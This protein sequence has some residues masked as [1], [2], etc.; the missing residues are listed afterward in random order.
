MTT[1]FL[2]ELREVSRGNPDKGELYEVIKNSTEKNDTILIAP[3]L[4][5]IFDFER[6]VSRPSL[7]TFKYIPTSNATLIEWYKRLKFKEAVFS[8][9]RYSG[10]DYNY[11]HLIS[12]NTRTD[13]MFHA[14]HKKWFE[15]DSYIL[16]GISS[17]SPP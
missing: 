14:G 2:Q 8:G 9:S 17:S 15:N 16:W 12:S 10:S 5:K 1:N 4:E 11:S 6:E 3:D 7:V 13:E